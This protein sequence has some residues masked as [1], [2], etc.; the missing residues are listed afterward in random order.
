MCLAVYTGGTV[1]APLAGRKYT[2]RVQFLS[3]KPAYGDGQ[4]LDLVVVQS[5]N[6]YVLPLGDTTVKHHWKTL[7]F[8]GTLDASD[9]VALTPTGYVT[10]APDLTSGTAL[11]LGISAWNAGSNP[12]VNDYD[13]I[14]I[15]IE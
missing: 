13:N 3:G 5:G 12:V 15:T 1:S 9:F 6:T 8:T 4:G 14:A 10:A 2:V 11:E 7:T